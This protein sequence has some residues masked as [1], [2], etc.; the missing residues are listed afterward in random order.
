M[1]IPQSFFEIVPFRVKS[2]FIFILSTAFILLPEPALSDVY[3]RLKGLKITITVSKCNL[4]KSPEI[5]NNII[6][7]LNQNDE[8]EIIEISDE[9]GKLWYKIEAGKYKG[10]VSSKV[11]KLQEIR[12][13][14]D[15]SNLTYEKRFID[16]KNAY[17]VKY[18][19]LFEKVKKHYSKDDFDNLM[20][21]QESIKLDKAYFDKVR[22][23]ASPDSTIKQEQQHKDW[24][25]IL[26]NEETVKKG[27]IFFDKY[28]KYFL[29]AAKKTGVAASDIIAI[30]NWESRLGE[31]RGRYSVFTIFVG[32]YFYIDEIE[33]KIFK[34]GTYP[35]EN[36]MDRN[37]ALKRIDKLKNRAARNLANLLIQAKNKNF[38]PLKVKGSWAGAIGIPQFMPSSMVYAK[39]GDN[40]GN[41][42]LNT[43]PDAIMSVASYLAEHKYNEKG[44]EYAF[45]R[46]NRSE[47]YMRGV[48]LYSDKFKEFNTSETE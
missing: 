19:R 42:D 37:S 47:M 12:K 15:L 39:D 23:L 32:Q 43:I 13:E 45:K 40:D 33:Y 11:C 1:I 17:P 14:F 35:S 44:R 26:V 9:N 46:Y 7:K 25:P 24:V 29:E 27:K 30:L 10:W 31:Y 34:E 38:D 18:I 21:N 20:S 5:S 8:A 4:R 2:T 36:V 48:T 28:N 22:F 41:I 16:L 3:N 6:T